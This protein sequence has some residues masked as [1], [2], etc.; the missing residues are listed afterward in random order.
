MRSGAAA[1]DV[2]FNRVGVCGG[3]E[4]EGSFSMMIFLVFFGGGVGRGM[5]ILIG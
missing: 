1:A 3:G 2:G 5:M 4:G